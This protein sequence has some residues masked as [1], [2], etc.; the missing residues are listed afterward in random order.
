MPTFTIFNGETVKIL[1]GVKPWRNTMMYVGRTNDG[2][3]YVCNTPRCSLSVKSL[4][5][6]EITNAH[7]GLQYRENGACEVDPGVL[8]SVP[9]DT[10]QKFDASLRS[11]PGVVPVSSN[12]PGNYYFCN[13]V[14]GK[15][16]IP[17]GES[18][19]IRSF[20]FM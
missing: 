8:F 4:D 9:D 18:M 2:D 3:I 5:Q 7:S 17:D 15:C 19:G 1:I 16:V 10:H 14:A 12:R 11:T 20:K 6:V 13:S